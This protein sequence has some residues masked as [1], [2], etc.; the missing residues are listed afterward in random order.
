MA[1]LDVAGQVGHDSNEQLALAFGEV[2]S[3]CFFGH[4]CDNADG[5]ESCMEDVML[6]C[7]EDG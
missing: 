7:L 1:C 4:C 3:F 2:D 5:E 6:C